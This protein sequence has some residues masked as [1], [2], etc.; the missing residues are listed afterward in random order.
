[1]RR[2]ERAVTDIDII[3]GFI[4]HEE[5]IRLGL[6]DADGMYIVPVNY[7]Y[8]FADGI[9]TFF[10]HGAS[11]GRKA[12]IIRHGPVRACFEL[13]GDHESS[14][15]EGCD[16]TYYYMSIIGS[17]TV[18]EITDRDEKTAALDAIMKHV[19]RTTGPFRYGEQALDATMVSGL[20]VDTYTAKRNRRI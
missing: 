14:I 7:G 5:V 4:D 13:D 12:D 3:R 17:G 15:C 11:A 8:A 16:S 2:K 9:L 20:T 19:G 1:M 18:A 6:S 10:F